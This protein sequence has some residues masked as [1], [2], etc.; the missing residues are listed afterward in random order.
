MR[1]VL[2]LAILVALSGYAV[3]H[4]DW[5]EGGEAEVLASPAR[6]SVQRVPDLREVSAERLVE[7]REEIT[8]EVLFGSFFHPYEEGT[9]DPLS[10]WTDN[11]P[12]QLTAEGDE[13][14]EA[15]YEMRWWVPSGHDVVA[16][17]LVFADARGA[18]DFVDRAASVRCREEATAQPA[19]FPDGGRNLEW[20]N[21]LGYMQQDLFLARGP[22][23]YRLAI[24]PPGERQT[25]SIAI[26]KEGFA[27]VN[28]LGCALLKS[29]CG[30]PE[31]AAAL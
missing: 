23:V 19:P 1:L 10:A 8:S 20:R 6:C 24:V 28:A 22:R 16:D 15:G 2:L 13:E 4:V 11:E 26:R 30:S 5:D 21:P 27:L 3:T 25:P 31:A 12:V 14:V 18:R 9:V 29:D 7:L 17:V